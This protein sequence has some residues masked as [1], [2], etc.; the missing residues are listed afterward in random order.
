M[1]VSLTVPVHKEDIE[2]F[3]KCLVL[4]HK[5]VSSDKA[6]DFNTLKIS[7]IRLLFR[8]NITGKK[9]AVGSSTPLLGMKVK[10]HETFF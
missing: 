8:P 7:L 4:M 10:L 5:R 2:D 6:G 9:H 1:A 3:F